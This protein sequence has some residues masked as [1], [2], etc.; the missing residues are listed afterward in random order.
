MGQGKTRDYR[1]GWA[2]LAEDMGMVACKVLLEGVGFP[3]T[4][5]ASVI[6]EEMLAVCGPEMALARR[7]DYFPVPILDLE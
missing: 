2:S 3:Y 6:V 1:L 4:G 5:E 7:S